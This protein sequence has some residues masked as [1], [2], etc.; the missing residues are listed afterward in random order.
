MPPLAAIRPGF[1]PTLAP[2]R[3]RISRPPSD[4]ASSLP[5]RSSVVTAALVP[6]QCPTPT[7]ASTFSGPITYLRPTLHDSAP[8]VCRREPVRV[9]TTI[10]AGYCM[11]CRACLQG[12]L[13]DKLPAR[14]RR[15]RPG[16]EPR[17]YIPLTPGASLGETGAI[18]RTYSMAMLEPS[19]HQ[20]FPDPLLSWPD[21][22]PT[23]L[24]NSVRP[25]FY[26][27]TVRTIT[28]CTSWPHKL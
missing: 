16:P 18:D 23:R 6:W 10:T 9:C 15:L 8:A 27:Q 26:D 24:S 28:T 2:A 3:P 12:D 19:A 4:P 14:A 11:S 21:S 20:P 13:S 1:Q 17:R 25:D 22:K 5:P 7:R